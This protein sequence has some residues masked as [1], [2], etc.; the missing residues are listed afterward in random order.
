MD[1]LVRDIRYGFRSLLKRP[2][3]SVIALIAL[4][5]GIGANTAIFSLVNAVV[6]KPLP[7]H[8]PDQ[9]VWVFGNIRN[10]GNRASVAPLDF[11][12]YRN[13]NKTFEQFAAH[14]GG[15]MALT[16]TG[17]GEP[18]RLSA[19]GVTGNYFQ[20]LGVTP[21]LGRG[22][23][24]ENEKTG[25]DQVA[26]LS[27]A[28]WLKRF[29]GDASVLNKTI[30]L[31]GR[32][33]EIIGVMPKLFSF[34]Q[35][36]DLWVP[37]NFDSSPE[38]KQRKA[39]FLRPI[40]RLKSGVTLAQA[41]ADTDVIAREMERLY[42]ESNTGWNLRI[43]SLRDQLIG[44]TQGTIFILF[45]AV[46]LV[47][48][49]ACANVANL[50][51]V[52]AA[53]RQKEVALRAALGAS[54]WRIMR[55][56]ITE[57]LLLA[58]FG[59]ALGVLL[60]TWGVELLLKLGEGSIP[61]TA[62]VKIDATVLGFTLLVS[63]TTGIL[64]GLAPALR[65][66]KLSLT[67]SLK[68]AGRGVGEGMLRN[69]TRSVL[70]VMESAIAVVLLIGAGLLIRS[71]VELLKTNPGF[72]ADNVLTMRIDLP[73]KKYDTP[74]KA[75]NFYRE[76][77]TRVS[78]L[79]GVE[80]AG[81]VTE[82]PLSGQLNDMPFTVEGRPPVAPNEAFGADFRRVN[83]HYFQALRI[84]LLRGRNFSENEVQQSSK[85]L[86]VS[87]QLVSAV[88]PNEEPIGKRLV[89]AM[90]NDQWE[91]IGIVG[92][93]RDRSLAGPPLAAMYLPTRQTARNNLVIRNGEN[94][95]SLA[96]AVRREV[97]A[98]DPDQPVAAVRTMN[99]WIDTSV[100]GPRYRTMLLAIF[101]GVALLL[102]STGIYGVM[103]YSVAQRTHEIGVRMA[104]GA[105]RWDVLKLVIR[106][107]MVL[108]VIGVI[109]GLFGAFAL[110]R[111]MSSLVFG[112]TTKDPVTF[113]AVALVLTL[114]ALIACYIPARRATKVDPLVA[115]RYE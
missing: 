42:P 29:G 48:L 39:H 44:N 14:F 72:D 87:E 40:G 25:Q 70:V 36:A 88:F 63:L 54:S 89:L 92:D 99:D 21:A 9:L 26:V 50:L 64:F 93:I 7:F 38:M 65:T 24:L 86:L 76:L 71:L 47:L 60:A 80:A 75:A 13:E 49:I 110:T 56:V 101:A 98:I 97:Q 5:L 55:Q 17:S 74:E 113:A 19:S 61:L 30:V 27:H 67:D 52:R 111:V 4:A 11:L 51:L 43:V 105:R 78:N 109:L 82:L 20:A 31:D 115:L 84:P 90:G 6:L 94:P 59:G 35:N 62:D 83:Q 58:L 79:P 102:A 66:L 96:G 85:V 2:G 81:T 32:S 77:E 41:Q 34:P 95:L 104:L 107:G 91:I 12:D 22:F 53:S 73:R 69:R 15:Q 37:M 10:G 45:G 28:F 33:V 3:V 23:S 18:E 16:L 108:V 46:G 1:T 114:V 112:V 57:S 103:S 68:E 100:A 106:Q 8:E